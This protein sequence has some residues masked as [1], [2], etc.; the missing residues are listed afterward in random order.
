V[1]YEITIEKSLTRSF[2]VEAETD[3]EAIEKAKTLIQKADQ[4]PAEM[5]NADEYW[6][7]KILDDRERT[8]VDWAW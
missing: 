7:Y 3:E 4:S 5:D 2:E 8:V 6:D 1:K